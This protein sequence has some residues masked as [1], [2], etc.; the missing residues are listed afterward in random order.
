MKS[1]ST[2]IL[3]LLFSFYST[4]FAHSTINYPCSSQTIKAINK[5]VLNYLNKNG[6]PQGGVNIE[7]HQ[8][9]ES[10]ASAKIHPKQPVTDI[11]TVY[12]NFKKN[13]WT[14][15][16]LGTDFD[17]AMLSKLPKPLRNT[18]QEN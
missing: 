15:M 1:L 18:Y 5:T 17:K 3:I 8:C 11:A 6:M 12:L 7:K 10:Y 13:N 2:T 9:V 4:A 16:S 14:V